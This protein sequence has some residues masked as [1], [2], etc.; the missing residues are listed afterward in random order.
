MSAYKKLLKTYAKCGYNELVGMAKEAINKLVPLIDGRDDEMTPGVV[1]Y[2]ALMAATAADGKLSKLEEQFLRDVIGL[3][4][5]EIRILVN[6]YEDRIG[7][8]VDKFYDS[9]CDGEAKELLLSLVA[10]TAA[11]D[12][13]VSREETVYLKQLIK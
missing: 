12:R 1:V 5:A 3:G 11:V 13:S 4:D 7:N 9:L 6:H 8:N 10:M 2:S